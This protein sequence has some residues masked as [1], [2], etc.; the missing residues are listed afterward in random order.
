MADRPEAAPWAGV[1]VDELPLYVLEDE[2]EARQRLRA[3]AVAVRG[4]W[5]TLS[6]SAPAGGWWPSVQRQPLVP[7]S[8]PVMLV[9][10]RVIDLAP[11]LTMNALEQ[12]WQ[13]RQSG[14]ALAVG[15]DLLE[16]E[17]PAR[18]GS[19]SPCLMRV[20]TRLHR[21]SRWSPPQRLD[22]EVL[23]WSA[24]RTELDLRPVGPVRRT[25]HFFAIGHELLAAVAGEL[26][27]RVPEGATPAASA[28]PP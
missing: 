14:V 18:S 8:M 27:A 23:G 13:E 7:T 26:F 11:G 24:S 1:L 5:R 25:H 20:R 2:R 4:Q 17:R 28:C 16:V 19:S 3:L 21:P 15:P 6:S 12:W 22:L 10:T 9:I